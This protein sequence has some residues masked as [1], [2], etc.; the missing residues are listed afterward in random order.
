MHREPTVALDAP[1][2]GCRILG[3]SLGCD[4]WLSGTRRLVAVVLGHF[5]HWYAAGPVFL[6]PVSLLVL[7]I[8]AS[9]WREKR[10]A[11]EE[12]TSTLPWMRTAPSSP[13]TAAWIWRSPRSW[14]PSS[15][16][17][18]PAR[19]RS[20]SWTYKRRPRSKRSPSPASRNYRTTRGGRA[21]NGR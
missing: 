14:K 4:P 2:E 3:A 16:S 15:P 1:I 17:W 8:K 13:S 12:L 19:S 18:L 9:E 7:A 6:A 21:S 5:G 20:P 11:G 10:R